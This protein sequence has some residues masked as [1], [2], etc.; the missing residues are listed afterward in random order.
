[1]SRRPYLWLLAL[2]VLFLAAFMLYPLLKMFL[3]SLRNY[4]SALVVGTRF[5]LEN[6]TKLFFDPFYQ[7]VLARTLRLGAIVSVVALGLAYPVAYYLARTTSRGK[8]W[9]VFLLLTPL[10]VGIVV[11]SYG[12]IVL[13][14]ANGAVNRLLLAGGLIDEPLR[15]LFTD[16]AVLIGLIEVLVPYMILPLISALQKV[17]ITL[18]EAAATLGA[19]RFEVFRRVVLPLSLPGVVSGITI[20]FTLSAGAIVTP[21][22]LGGPRMQTVGTLIY[23][24]MTNTVNWPFG[25]A[26][27]FALLIVEALPICL[28][29][30]LAPAARGAR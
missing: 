24:L 29:F 21:A 2:P 20:V 15:I 28:L 16:W 3:I 25:S 30:G 26:L 1:M 10:M 18:E 17:D 6:Y 8:G 13:L 9:L 11:R 23:Q 27:A 22:V 12:W 14:G 4:D 7:R 19:S 5:T